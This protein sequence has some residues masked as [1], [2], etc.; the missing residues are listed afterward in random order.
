MQEVVVVVRNP[1]AENDPGEVAEGYFIEEEGFVTL[2]DEK[3][4]PLGSPTACNGQSPK[5]IAAVLTKSRWAYDRGG[6]HKRLVYSG[7]YV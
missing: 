5:A 2:T 3:G 1:A 7:T 6:F 4:K